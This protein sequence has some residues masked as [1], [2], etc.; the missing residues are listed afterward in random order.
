M[1]SN[2]RE[3]RSFGEV[4]IHLVGGGVLIDREP[5]VGLPWKS[6]GQ[7]T[8]GLPW[9]SDGQSTDAPPNVSEG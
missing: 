3:R 8:D 7:S 9:K 1:T 4:T 2:W 5:I 6:D